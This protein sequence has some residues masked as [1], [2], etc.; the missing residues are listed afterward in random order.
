MSTQ[1][2]ENEVAGRLRIARR[3]SGLTQEEAAQ[4]LGVRTRTIARWET[5]ETKGFLDDLERIADVYGTTRDELLGV[6]NGAP[7]EE[8][9]AAMETE[10]RELRELLLDPTRVRA[11]ADALI[12][13][14]LG[15]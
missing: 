9:L 10:L 6:T 11:L 4:A 1:P 8:R 12:A 13:E 2:N 5:G 14:E 15:E 3:L 7:M